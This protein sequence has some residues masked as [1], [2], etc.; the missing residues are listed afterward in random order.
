M[1]LQKQKSL[2]QMITHNNN[3]ISFN[4]DATSIQLIKNVLHKL[5]LLSDKLLIMCF[6]Y[7]NTI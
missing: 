2:S 1:K 7:W 4:F 5:T 6:Y 3:L